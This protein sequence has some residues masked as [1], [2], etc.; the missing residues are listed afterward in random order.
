MA[1][2]PS[3]LAELLGIEVIDPRT[4]RALGRGSRSRPRSASR[5][6]SSTAASSRARR[7]DLLAARPCGGQAATAWSRWASRTR[8]PSSARSAPG[9][10]TPRRVPATR[11][12]DL[13]LGRGD[14]RRRG[15]P[16]RA[17]A[18]DRR[19]PPDARRT[20]GASRRKRFVIGRRRSR[21]NALRVIRIPGG[22]WRRLYSARST[23][24]ITS[25]TTSAREAPR[26]PA[27]RA[28]GRAR[29]RPRGSGR[30]PRRAA[31]SPRRAGRGAARP[32]ARA[33]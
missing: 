17:R 9:A 15:P 5:S 21:P 22:A 7:D 14:H 16:L 30:A 8:R 20:S 25:S 32:R 13:D 23:S 12:H 27:P 28:S 29:R 1:A 4:R 19:G 11:P 18:D 10:S 31:A 2:P 26:R 3:H 24:V 33:R 6:G